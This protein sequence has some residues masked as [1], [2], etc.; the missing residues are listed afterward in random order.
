MPQQQ[1]SVSFKRS[2]CSAFI[3]LQPCLFLPRATL[4][5]FAFRDSYPESDTWDNRGIMLPHL[6]AV[7]PGQDRILAVLRLC[8]RVHVVH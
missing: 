5:N 2:R 8:L 1:C 3:H 6:D 4:L 7:Q